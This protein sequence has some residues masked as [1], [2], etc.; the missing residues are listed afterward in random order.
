MQASTN[1]FISPTYFFFGCTCIKKLN[2][3]FFSLLS[4]RYTLHFIRSAS[5]H[6]D[7][8]SRHIKWCG[9]GCF[10]DYSLYV[11]FYVYNASFKISDI[12]SVP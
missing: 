12:C 3:G 8:V 7:Q 11:M 5:F 1:L 2:Y 4:L 10:L 9:S 6:L